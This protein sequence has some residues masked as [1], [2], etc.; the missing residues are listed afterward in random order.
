MHAYPAAGLHADMLLFDI[1][2][3]H[4]PLYPEKFP[5]QVRLFQHRLLSRG[6]LQLEILLVICIERSNLK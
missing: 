6:V 4:L 1:T 5:Q 2:D 3:C